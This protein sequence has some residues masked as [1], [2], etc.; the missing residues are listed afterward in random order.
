MNPQTPPRS[1]IKRSISD[2]TLFPDEPSQASKITEFDSP[3]SSRLFQ[4]GEPE[5]FES[6]PAGQ[7]T[8]PSPVDE[9]E[10]ATAFDSMVNSSILPFIG[11]EVF[12]SLSALQTITEQDKSLKTLTARSCMTLLQQRQDLK[13]ELK[14]AIDMGSYTEI[15]RLRAWPP[16]PISRCFNAQNAL[17]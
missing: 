13:A 6:R 8:T 5:S 9:P 11:N 4:S 16:S 12:Q 7:G 14:K 15:R 1:G 10:Q 17:N 3:R 2:S